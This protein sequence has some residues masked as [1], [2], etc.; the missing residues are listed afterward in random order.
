MGPFC[1][2]DAGNKWILVMIDYLLKW[3]VAVALLDKKA[4]M[5]AWVFVEQL[6]CIHGAP[7]CLLSDQGKEFLNEVLLS[8]NNEL[9]VHCLKTTAYHPQTD[10]LTERFNLMLQ[11][12]LSMYVADHQCDWD[13]YIPY[14]LAAYCCLV[15]EAMLETPFYLVFGWDHYLPID[16]SLGLP[17]A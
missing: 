12:M 5:V 1:E 16:V 11:N 10:G 14:V 2:S 15:N 6:V 13:T 4:E 8:V 17:R 9:W 7:E 3:L